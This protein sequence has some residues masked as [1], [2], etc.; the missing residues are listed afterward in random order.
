M[1]KHSIN[2]WQ[3]SGEIIAEVL[4]HPVIP[5]DISIKPLIVKYWLP[6]CLFFKIFLIKPKNQSSQQLYFFVPSLSPDN[7][8]DYP[9]WDTAGIP[10]QIGK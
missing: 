9:I 3:G 2:N 5:V 4:F 10:L 7:V 8:A 6:N 1:L